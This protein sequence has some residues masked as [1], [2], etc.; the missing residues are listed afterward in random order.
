VR[1]GS[2]CEE[3]GRGGGGSQPPQAPRAWQNGVG[4]IRYTTDL[5]SAESDHDH[6][7]FWFSAMDGYCYLLLEILKLSY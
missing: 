2:V 3:G 7:A 5:P 6:T 1:V 4:L